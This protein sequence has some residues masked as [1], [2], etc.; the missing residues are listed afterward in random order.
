MVRWW[1]EVGK[2]EFPHCSRAEEREMGSDIRWGESRVKP[3]K[4]S[5]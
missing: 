5:G 3:Y 1:K 2:W 4:T